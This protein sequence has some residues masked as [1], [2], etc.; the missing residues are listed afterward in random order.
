MHIFSF[1]HFLSYKIFTFIVLKYFVILVFDLFGTR[2]SIFPLPI[3]SSK[4]AINIWLCMFYSNYSEQ[5]R[6][7]EERTNHFIDR[8][9]KLT[10]ISRA[11]SYYIRRATAWYI[12]QNLLH[13]R[14]RRCFS[15]VFPNHEEWQLCNTFQLQ[16][17]Q[18]KISVNAIWLSC[19]CFCW[20]CLLQ[21]LH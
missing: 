17:R 2:N 13:R 21:P 15:L 7:C 11:Y 16:S 1:H 14:L 8:V 12:E 4:P 9:C 5:Y 3:Y 6:N 10:Y 18:T 20:G 19:G